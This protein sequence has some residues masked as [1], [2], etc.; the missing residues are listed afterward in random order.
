M[1]RCRGLT[2]RRTRSRG[3]RKAQGDPQVPPPGW[4]LPP[5]VAAPPLT[6][7]PTW[8]LFPALPVW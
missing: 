5:Q 2:E 1:T 6:V 7:L 8:G 3:A 4:P